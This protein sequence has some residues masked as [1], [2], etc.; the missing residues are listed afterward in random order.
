MAQIVAVFRLPAGGID[1]V[2]KTG[3]TGTYDV[4]LYFDPGGRIEDPG[5]N[6]RAT[7]E[8]ELGLRFEK[9]KVPMDV[10]VVDHIEKVPTEN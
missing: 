1:V 10:L 6:F 4:T 9:S 3:L 2:D 7:V 8:R 5:G